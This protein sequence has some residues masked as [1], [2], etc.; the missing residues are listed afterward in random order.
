MHRPRNALQL[1][2]AATCGATL[3]AAA[4]LGTGTAAFAVAGDAPAAIET[5]TDAAAGAGAPG[6]AAPATEEPLPDEQPP[7]DPPSEGGTPVTDAGGADPTADGGQMAPVDAQPVD[8]DQSVARPDAEGT[9]TSPVTALAEREDE[10]LAGPSAVPEEIVYT[11]ALSID[12]PESVAMAGDLHEFTVSVFDYD[13]EQADSLVLT[14]P[15]N[16]IWFDLQYR[17]GRSWVDVSFE[18]RIVDLRAE[19]PLDGPEMLFRIGVTEQR[20][21]ANQLREDEFLALSVSG[22]EQRSEVAAE[23]PVPTIELLA[24][25]ALAG[26][27]VGTEEPISVPVLSPTLDVVSE[28]PDEVSAGDTF[29][30]VVEVTNQTGYTY[31]PSSLIRLFYP[32]FV[33]TADEEDLLDEIDQMLNRSD[34]TEADFEWIDAT[35]D[36]IFTLQP[37]EADLSCSVDRGPAE[38]LA[39]GTETPWGFRSG[40]YQDL[41]G[42]AL[43]SVVVECEMTV[44]QDVPDG[45]LFF[46]SWLTL[47]NE[48]LTLAH[49]PNAVDG[50]L[51]VGIVGQGAPA[52]PPAPK[53]EPQPSQPTPAQPAP[54]RPTPSKP[55]AAAPIRQV[56]NE[57]LP[58]TGID[59]L[60][61]AAAGL[62]LVLAGAA[63]LLGGRRRAHN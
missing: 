56:G 35:V 22:V 9:V 44:G 6:D 24:Q 50:L 54:V 7:T 51:A 43:G 46:D 49:D 11:P 61:L 16:G 2:V 23:T 34:L 3:L 38:R 15:A 57:H 20:M 52:V 31:Q 47:G 60:P 37:G 53:P 40:A 1:L 32:M 48:G 41:G 28:L 42:L 18:N 19:I 29:D 58:R 39:V 13:L 55:P 30:L 59:P 5:T 4:V 21:R 63:A 36:E 10:Q 45:W 17:Q 12:A 25:L 62:G 27:P 14:V 26:A 8:G 33:L